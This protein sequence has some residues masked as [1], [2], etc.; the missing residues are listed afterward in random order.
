M[1]CETKLRECLDEVDANTAMRLW[2]HVF[3]NLPQITDIN[4]AIVAIHMARTSAKSISMA[5]RLYSHAWL[6]ERGYPSQLPIEL[7]PPAERDRPTIVKAVGVAVMSTSRRIDR[8][9]EAAA[10]EKVMSDAAGDM[11]LSGITDTVRV[12]A[13]MWQARAKW[14][15]R[16]RR[17]FYGYKC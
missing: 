1:L 3:P 14:I 16:N 7:R 8:I 6:T 10:I 15:A 4:E 9:E 17:R 2:K 11:M 5:K 13:H 12:A